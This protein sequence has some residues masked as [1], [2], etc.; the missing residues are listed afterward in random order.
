VPTAPQKGILDSRR[1][2]AL[3]IIRGREGCPAVGACTP[4]DL[5]SAWGHTVAVEILAWRSTD[6]IADV[7]PDYLG[8]PG[9]GAWRPTPPGFA[10]GFGV[11]YA[12]MEPWV[13]GFASRFHPA[14]PPALGSARYRGLQR[15][16][17]RGQRDRRAPDPRSDRVLLLLEL[18]HRARH[19]DR[20]RGGPRGAL[21]RGGSRCAI[22]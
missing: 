16:E 20:R 3:E 7:L 15:G 11:Q 6:G 10:P 18:E 9:A 4:V 1:A 8:G 13:I 2:V 14:G 22:D 5:G 21:G 12:D 19:L 17:V